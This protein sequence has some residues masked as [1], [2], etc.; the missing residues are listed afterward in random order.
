MVLL[1]SQKQKEI[2]LFL[3]NVTLFP[4]M[5]LPLHIFEQRYR[6]MMKDIMEGNKEFGV[7]LIKSGNEVGEPAIPY[8]VGTIALVETTETLCDGR[9]NISTIGKERFRIN[10][11]IKTI[12]YLVADVEVLSEDQTD[13][14]ELYQELVEEVRLL[15]TNYVKGLVGLKGGWVQTVTLPSEVGTLVYFIANVL[16]V[17]SNVRQQL[18]EMSTTLKRLEAEAV[19][20]REQVGEIKGNIEK[21]FKFPKSGLN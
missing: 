4:G 11:I 2:P 20:L 10:S 6:T 17:G 15:A 8:P 12:P 7:V 16:H 19:I 13:D 18:L 14:L 3:L 5:T 1:V 9:M 21:R